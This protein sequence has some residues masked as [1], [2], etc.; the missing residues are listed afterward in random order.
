MLAAIA[1]VAQTPSPVITETR[2]TY[3]AIKNNLIKA[4]EKMPDEDYKFRPVAEIRTFGELMAHIADSQMRTC[5]AVNGEMKQG[6]AASK[7]TR[8]DIVSALKDSFAE[9]DKA[10]DGL[11]A[12]NILEMVKF[13]NGERTRLGILTY[14]TGHESEEY[15]YAAV[16]LR[17][18]GI[19]P[20]S[21]ERR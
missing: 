20:P 6:T 4:A 21:S 16:Y 14:D 3:T 9:C 12:A 2:Q 1:A 19:V 18:K 11:T 7:T 13:R 10:W 15:G 5:S 17:L 8:A